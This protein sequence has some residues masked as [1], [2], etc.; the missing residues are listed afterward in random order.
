MRY[1]KDLKT[2]NPRESLPGNQSTVDQELSG[3]QTG[4]ISGQS[5]KDITSYIT[6]GLL[7]NNKKQV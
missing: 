4:I 7:S 5:V 6:T 2:T 1:F 3:Y